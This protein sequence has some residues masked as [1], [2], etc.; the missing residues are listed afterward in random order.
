MAPGFRRVNRG[1]LPPAQLRS[2]T[3][4]ARGDFT[5]NNSQC[6]V[7]AKQPTL[8]DILHSGLNSDSTKRHLR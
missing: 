7:Y 2:L 4:A 8:H 6:R 3:R 5:A 1:P